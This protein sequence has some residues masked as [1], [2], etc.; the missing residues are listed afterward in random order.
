MRQHFWKRWHREYLNELTRR[1][2]WTKGAHSI[3]EGT[4][5]LLREDNIPPMQ[6]ALG[7]V[8]K[9]HPGS[10]G[11]VRAVTVKT[12]TGVLDRSTKKLVPLLYQ[13]EDIPGNIDPASPDRAG[14]SQS[15]HR[16]SS[17]DRAGQS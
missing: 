5:V 6:W 14:Q 12:A 2:K 11:I 16:P 10:D 9:V 13:P 7:R 3:K 1:T 15:Q 8:T 4:V 17:P